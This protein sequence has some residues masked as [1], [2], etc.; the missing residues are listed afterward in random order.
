MTV[1]AQ[2]HASIPNRSGRARF[3]VDFRTV[4]VDADCTGTPIRGLRRVAD[5]APFDEES[6]TRL[7]GL[8][9]TGSTLVFAPPAMDGLNA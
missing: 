3:G 8:P 5:G 7:F 4:D 9:P 6:V 2:L 1:F